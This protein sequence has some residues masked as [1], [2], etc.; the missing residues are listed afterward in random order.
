[1]LQASQLY[2]LHVYTMGNKIY[3][4]R[5]AHILDPTGAYFAGRIISKGDTL[6]APASS[7]GEP[8]AQLKSK[9][10]DGVLGMES[11]VLIIDDNA[12]VWP[13]HFHNLIVVERYGL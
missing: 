7:P 11:S 3:A 13:H 10:L 9:D 2:E 12:K 4:T 1:M 6:D 5:M 8:P